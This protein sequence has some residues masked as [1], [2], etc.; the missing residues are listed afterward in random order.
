MSLTC[1]GVILT[2]GFKSLLSGWLRSFPCHLMFWLHKRFSNWSQLFA[3]SPHIYN[4]LNL[5]GI[6]VE[7]NIQ[8]PLFFFCEFISA[9]SNRNHGTLEVCR[10]REK[11]KR[12]SLVS[13]SHVLCKFMVVAHGWRWHRGDSQLHMVG[14]WRIEQHQK[15]IAKR[16]SFYRISNFY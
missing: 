5:C 2:I 7:V 8:N 13:I 14:I 15:K 9:A 4:R 12:I 11:W 6:S 10:E 16:S 3:K 1:E